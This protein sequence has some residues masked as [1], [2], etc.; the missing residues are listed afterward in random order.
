MLGKNTCMRR[1]MFISLLIA[2]SAI[3]YFSVSQDENSIA[4]KSVKMA[5]NLVNKV[6]TKDLAKASVETA[7]PAASTDLT[8][9]VENGTPD[10]LSI[11]DLNP[12]D[13]DEWIENE[14]T[15]LDSTHNKTANVEIRMKAQARTLRPEQL[16]ELQIIT[17]DSERSIN[18][19]ILSG[20]LVSLATDSVAVQTL[21]EIAGTPLPPLGP[22]IPHSE[23]EVKRGQELAIRYSEVDELWERAKA[24]ANALKSLKQLAQAAPEP[25]VRKYAAGRLKELI[26]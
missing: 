4:V 16:K 26:K 11:G 5:Q 7:K 6:T 20:Y 18:S 15:S 3:Y 17:L 22:P 13:L 1:L 24:D 2:F 19:R 21:T 10:E 9:I 12:A 25:A 14:S 23:D 8:T